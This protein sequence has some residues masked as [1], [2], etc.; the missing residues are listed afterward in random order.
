MTWDQV[1]FSMTQLSAPAASVLVAFIIGIVLLV[2]IFVRYKI[3]KSESHYKE[4]YREVSKS[5]ESWRDKYWELVHQKKDN[6]IEH[7]RR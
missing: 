2:L 6:V 7:D 1:A 3:E 4:M 5:S